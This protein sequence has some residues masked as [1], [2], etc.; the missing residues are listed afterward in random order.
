MPTE[1][2]NEAIARKLVQHVLRGVSVARYEDGSRD[3]M[4]DAQITYPDGTVAALEVVGDHDPNYRNLDARIRDGGNRIDAPTLRN[5]WILN[6]KDHPDVSDVRAIRGTIV[7][8]L[9]DLEAARLHLDDGHHGLR[10]H[11]G[12]RSGRTAP[13]GCAETARRNH[14]PLDLQRPRPAPRGDV[15]SRERLA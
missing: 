4:V 11:L 7:A 6:L 13:H 12:P 3:G 5:T 2:D 8:L 1:R 14:S 10:G 9:E 15:G